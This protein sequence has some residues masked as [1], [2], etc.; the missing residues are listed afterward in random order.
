M[1]SKRTILLVITVSSVL[2]TVEKRHTH[3]HFKAEI[4]TFLNIERCLT[5]PP[6]INDMLA[7]VGVNVGR[8]FLATGVW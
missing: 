4:F 1:D 5:L 2:A 8:F 3:L 6:S 7:C